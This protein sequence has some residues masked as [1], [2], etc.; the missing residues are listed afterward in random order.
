MVIVSLSYAGP[1]EPAKQAF[2]SLL[3]AGAVMEQSGMTPYDQLNAGAD[4][5]GMKGGQKPVYGTSMLN[6]D[7][8]ALKEAWGLYVAF[9]GKHP[10]AGASFAMFECYSVKKVKEMSADETAFP[11]RECPYHA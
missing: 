6:F 2:S 7:P 4:S 1:E 3:S 10:S 8:K 5:F 9:L 11:H